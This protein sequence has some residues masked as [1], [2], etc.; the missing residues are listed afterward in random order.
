MITY[1]AGLG[2]CRRVL[3]PARATGVRSSRPTEPTERPL[4][5]SGTRR[6]LLEML[7]PDTK[8]TLRSRA[9]TATATATGHTNNA[10]HRSRDTDRDTTR[11]TDSACLITC[12]TALDGSPALGTP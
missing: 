2:P 6:V 12:A 1:E 11:I 10:A 3:T 5:D 4:C 9:A 8:G 7:E